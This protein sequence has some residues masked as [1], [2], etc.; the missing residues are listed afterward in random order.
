[1]RYKFY[2][3][4]CITTVDRLLRRTLVRFVILIIKVKQSLLVSKVNYREV[5]FELQWH[6]DTEGHGGLF[7]CEILCLPGSNFLE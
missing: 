5:F 6:R 2:E 4:I 1:M 3:P 7:L